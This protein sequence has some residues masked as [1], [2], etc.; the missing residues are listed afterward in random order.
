[1]SYDTCGTNTER[2]DESL[3]L[4]SV[5]DVLEVAVDVA[6]GSNKRDEFCVPK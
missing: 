2:D 4:V 5:N 1:V 3:G 6:D